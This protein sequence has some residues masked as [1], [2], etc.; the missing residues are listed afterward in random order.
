MKKIY[1]LTLGLIGLAGASFAQNESSFKETEVS[2]TPRSISLDHSTIQNNGQRAPQICMDTNLWTLARSFGSQGATYAIVSMNNTASGILSFGTYVDVPTG[3]SVTITGFQ[4]LARSIRA[5][6]ANVSVTAKIYN[7]GADSLPTGAAL[8]SVIVSVDTAQTWVQS[9]VFT[10]PAMANG[11]FVMTLEN[12]TT[13]AD[14]IDILVGAQGSGIA[15]NQPAVMQQG[16]VASGNYF[17]PTNVFGTV[18]PHFYPYVIFQQTSTFLMSVSQ[19]TGPNESVDFT[20]TAYSIR[21]HPI[22]SFNPLA[23]LNSTYYSVDGGSSFSA[24]SNGDTSI[25]FVD[26]TVDY[27]IVMHDS[28]FMWTNGTCLITESATLLKASPNGIGETSASQF[29]AYFGNGTLNIINGHGSA[30]LY[31]I[32]GRKVKEFTVSNQF[33]SIEISDLNEGVYIL[34]IGEHVTKLKL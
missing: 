20:Y 3:T 11:S 5:D 15:D 23:V 16:G 25:T 18:L 24:A 34:Q 8:A 32:T 22:W 13:M 7:A 12:A 19:L 4:F 29:N 30:T 27:N 6:D 31:S 26:E 17:R 28:I 1:I 33:E 14:S 10:I 2:I 9:A 21:N